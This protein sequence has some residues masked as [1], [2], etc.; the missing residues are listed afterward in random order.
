MPGVTCSVQE[1]T[2]AEGVRT[3]TGAAP[4]PG[5]GS[6]GEGVRATGVRQSQAAQVAKKPLS[7]AG[8]SVPVGSVSRTVRAAS[9]AQAMPGS[10]PKGRSP[11]RGP[12]PTPSPRGRARRTPPGVRRRRR[13]RRPRR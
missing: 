9:T 8:A 5:A 10:P 13:S 11:G 1:R 3:V 7:R 12:V 6:S 2:G 4:G